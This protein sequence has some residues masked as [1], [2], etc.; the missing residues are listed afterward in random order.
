VLNE[1]GYPDS[2]EY[3]AGRGCLNKNRDSPYFFTKNRRNSFQRNRLACKSGLTMFP[4]PEAWLDII[5]IKCC[6]IAKKMKISI[7]D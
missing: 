7:V 3:I 4:Y 2:N 1:I 6:K 5:K